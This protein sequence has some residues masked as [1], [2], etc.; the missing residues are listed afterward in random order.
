MN[1]REGRSGPRFGFH[2]ETLLLEQPLEF[3]RLEHF[4]DDV[5]AADKLAFDVELRD[6]RPLGI[7]LDALPQVIGLEDVDA[8]VWHADVVEDLHDLA[9]ESAL[10]ELRRALHEQHHVVAFD[11]VVDPLLDAHLSSFRQA[12]L[13]A[14][15]AASRLSLTYM[16]RT[17]APQPKALA[18]YLLEQDRTS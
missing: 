18:G 2:R 12:F 16:Y 6:G 8:F 3:A 13:A 5:A 17:S 15:P 11:L 7:G 4:A 9:G 1:L 10:R 14:A